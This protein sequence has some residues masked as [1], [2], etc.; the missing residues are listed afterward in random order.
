MQKLMLEKITDA[1]SS[2]K[3]IF[4]DWYYSKLNSAMP[5]LYSSVDI[6]FS[7]QKLVPVDTNLFPAGFNN[8]LKKNFARASEEIARYI[9]HFFPKTRKILLIGENHTRNRFYLDSL[10]TL[11]T[12]ITKANYEVKLG[13]LESTILQNHQ[14]IID[15]YPI[16]KEQGFIQVE[17]FIPD[18]IILNNDL[19]SNMPIILEN[20]KQKI[21]PH[22]NNGWFNRRKSNHFKIYNNLLEELEKEINLPT[23]FIKSEFDVCNDIDFKLM[24]GI[25]ILASKVET[26]LQKIY[27]KYQEYEIKQQP[28]VV[29]KSDYGTYGMGVMIAK[30][31]DDVLR[32]N[33]KQRTQ[34][35]IT[36]SNIVNQRVIIQEGISTIDK[37]NNNIAEPL[38]YFINHQQI[39]F[40]YRSHKHKDQFSNLNSVGMEII[41]GY[42]PLDKNY[43]YCC[44]MVGRLATLAASLELR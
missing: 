28:Y 21:I 9:K 33:K 27:Q 24:R 29:I 5:C 18:L 37:V 36:K 30:S 35:H 13:S 20:S 44:N 39:D 41:N 26:L 40:F 4:D 19:S 34:M 16:F 14:K 8:L 3:N 38:L 25:D 31:G 22:P 2:K 6:R 11:E 7:G 1:V 43:L 23:Y 15:I 42:Q 17:N 32:L 10:K 12:L